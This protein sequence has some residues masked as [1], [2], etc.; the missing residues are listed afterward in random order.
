MYD[1]PKHTSGYE[2]VK[3]SVREARII[4]VTGNPLVG[5]MHT[6]DRAGICHQLANDDKL[7]WVH[8]KKTGKDA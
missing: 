4:Q 5:V 8:E 1:N 3:E 7:T 2:R 6:N